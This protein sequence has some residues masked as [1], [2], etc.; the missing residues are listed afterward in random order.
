M[1]DGWFGRSLSYLM[2][3]A[4]ALSGALDNFASPW[5]VVCLHMPEA[6]KTDSQDLMNINV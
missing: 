5:H 2:A 4:L 3:R 6:F 1:N